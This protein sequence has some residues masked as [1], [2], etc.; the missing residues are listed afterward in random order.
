MSDSENSNDIKVAAEDMKEF[1][2]MDS[3]EEQEKYGATTKVPAAIT[4]DI[5]K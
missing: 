1:F 3:D 5:L 4:T 2:F